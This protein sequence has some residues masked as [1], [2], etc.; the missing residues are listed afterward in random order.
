MGFWRRKMNRYWRRR[1][2]R[3]DAKLSTLTAAT[4][5]GYYG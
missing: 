2:D 5:S 1:R 3:R 4:A